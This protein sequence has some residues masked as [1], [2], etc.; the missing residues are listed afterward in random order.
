MQLHDDTK[1]NSAL[2]L[3]PK[4]GARMFLDKQTPEGLFEPRTECGRALIAHNGPDKIAIFFD[5]PGPKFRHQILSDDKVAYGRWWPLESIVRKGTFEG[6]DE[7]GIIEVEE[8]IVR[9]LMLCPD[10]HWEWKTIG[11]TAADDGFIDDYELLAAGWKEPFASRDSTDDHEAGSFEWLE[12][13][14]GTYVFE[15][16]Q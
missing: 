13:L 14:I 12:P 5:G 6:E 8:G 9:M 15:I 3:Q 16:I 11:V 10:G 1:E 7:L 2:N 4:P